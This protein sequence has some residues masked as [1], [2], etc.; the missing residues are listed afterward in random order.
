MLITTCLHNVD[1]KMDSQLFSL[2]CFFYKKTFVSQRNGTPVFNEPKEIGAGNVNEILDNIWKV[3][4]ESGCL[5]RE[6]IVEGETVGWS[7]DVP[8]ISHNQIDKFVQIFDTKGKRNYIPTNISS[9][10]LANLRNKDVHVVAFVYSRNV[11]TNTT[12]NLVKKNLLDPAV[13]DRSAAIANQLIDETIDKL[14]Q[15]HS[16]HLTTPQ[17]IGWR[18]WATF[19]ASKP[20]HSHEQLILDSPPDHVVV[21]FRNVPTN[22]SE[23]LTNA[24]Q[25]IRIARNVN[26][27][28]R[29]SL[30][31]IQERMA[32]IQSTMDLCQSTMQQ[33][34]QEFSNLATHLNYLIQQSERED[35]LLQDITDAVRTEESTFSME[36]AAQVTDCEDV[37]H[38]E[39]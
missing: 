27:I 3:L 38:M 2:K 32:Q 22:E 13:R 25:G 17:P 19:I 1:A 33:C 20:S 12:F 34:Q 15:A 35:S 26:G 8:D 4:I 24:Q 6:V 29:T 30:R 18:I 23:K 14:K 7:A 5:E 9:D 39:V 28:Q 10:L 36:S 37:D 31:G 11:S 16:H 21:L